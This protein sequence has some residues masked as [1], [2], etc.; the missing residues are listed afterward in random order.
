MQYTSIYRGCLLEWL[1]FQ[2]PSQNGKKPKNIANENSY[3]FSCIEIA[4]FHSRKNGRQQKPP[5]KPA[6]KLDTFRAYVKLVIWTQ[7][8]IQDGES[9]TAWLIITP[10]HGTVSFFSL[11]SSLTQKITMCLGWKLSSDWEKLDYMIRTVWKTATDYEP[12]AALISYS[13]ERLASEAGKGWY[14]MSLESCI[15]Q[16]KHPKMD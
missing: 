15:I 1:E 6:E 7:T 11:W 4:A 2:K 9:S 3:H 5:P 10:N 14:L 16:D 8:V 13:E 12:W